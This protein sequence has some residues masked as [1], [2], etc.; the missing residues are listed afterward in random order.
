[1]YIQKRNYDVFNDF[2]K[3]PFFSTGSEYSS[4]GGKLMKTDVRERQNDFVIDMELPGI[5]KE[6]VQAE[7]KDGYLTITAGRK[8]E[9]DGTEGK[10][11]RKERFEGSCKRSFYVGEYLTEEDINAEFKDGILS[12]T[13]PK[14]PEP[15][16]EQPK[17]ITIR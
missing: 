5:P 13:F 4:A 8:E 2:F 9:K 14:E 6:N 15:V 1:M 12:L 10:F 16:P 11:I 17:Y 7:L 3:A